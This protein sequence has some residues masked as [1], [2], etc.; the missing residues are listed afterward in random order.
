MKLVVSV[1]T[2]VIPVCLLRVRALVCSHHAVKDIVSSNA[3]VRRTYYYHNH[4]S[5]KNAL[6]VE[7]FITTVYILAGRPLQQHTTVDIYSG[8][9]G[10]VA[11][12]KNAEKNS[13]HLLL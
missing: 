7:S 2:V 5:S 1:V 10:F 13:T 4:V 11:E 3:V 12:P 6:L 9:G 8:G